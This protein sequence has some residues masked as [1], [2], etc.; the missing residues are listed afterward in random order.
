M[1]Q[2]G[3]ADEFSYQAN[4]KIPQLLRLMESMLFHGVRAAGAAGSPRSAGGLGTFITDNA[5]NA[6]STI[7]TKAFIDNCMELIM[8]DGGNPD[9][10]VCHPS[11][12]RD[13][14]DIVDTSSFVRLDLANQQVGMSPITRISTQYGDL[15]L[16]MSRWCPLA[17][18]WILDSRKV[19]VY[20]FDAFAWKQLGLTGDSDKGEVVGEYSLLVAN[21]KAHGYIYGLTS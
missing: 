10:L 11:V 12:G 15:R 14:K 8:L 1:E 20:E 16:V 4:K 17:K 19:G 18:S 3:I 2:H 21:D 5:V 7:I 13:I 6:S 9:L